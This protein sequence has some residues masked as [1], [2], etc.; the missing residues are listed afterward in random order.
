MC[1][2]TGLWNLN[3]E[4]VEPRVFD[5]FTD[6]LA[7]RGP[8]GRGVYIDAQLPLALGQRR[9]AIIDTSELG[10]QPMSY[11]DGRYWIV[12][13]GEIYNFLELRMELLA[14]GYQF[15]TDSDTE[16]ILAAYDRWGEDCLLRFNGM[17]AMA[18]WD[19]R[20][21]QLFVSRDRFGVK[22]M[23]YFY[24]GER[25]A[26]ASEM[27]AFLALDW[28]PVEF[29]EEMIATALT[30][31]HLIEGTER[32]LL[33][34][35]HRLPGGHCLT[36]RADG[37]LVKKRWWNTLDHLTEVPRR[38]DDQAER[39]KELF[40]DAC[41]IRMRSD[42]AIGTAL[43][44]GLDSSSV[45][46]AMRHIRHSSG[47]M[48]RLAVDWQRA[49]TAT[50]PGT[51]EDERKYAEEVIA[52]TGAQAV[53]SEIEPAMMLRHYND[54][55]FQFEEISDIHI[56][57]WQ[58][59]KAQRENNVIVSIDGHGG[60]ELLGGY[61]YHVQAALRDALKPFPRPWRHSDLK[62]T[63][64][65]LDLFPQEADYNI[66]TFSSLLTEKI[67]AFRWRMRGNGSTL[68]SSNSWLNYRP[69]PFS[70][71]SLDADQLRLRKRNLLFEKLYLS[72]HYADLP[73]NLRDFDRLSMAHGVEVRAPFLDWRLVTYS[74]SLPSASKM[75]YG[76]TK[77]ILR[78]AM[79]GVLT[80]SI[81]VRRSKGGF[82]NPAG[83]W[84]ANHAEPFIMDWL[85]SERFINSS[86]WHGRQIQQD[87][88][89]AFRTDNYY[90][91]HRGWLYLQAMHLMRLFRERATT[92]RTLV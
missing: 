86:I 81:R 65:S 30:H 22:P 72:F 20:I 21:K 37:S 34:R 51:P 56:G 4:F 6:S 35:L 5:M 43:S 83:A 28:F 36:V 44:G 64:L 60:D 9:L 29:D 8:D 82:V 57:P 66:P 17:W 61:Y 54:I 55:L 45:L 47:N 59:Y 52:H 50:Y 16:V 32:C 53:Y 39:F 12:Y 84:L 90:V 79:R 49:F 89:N 26:F 88:G 78:D 23:H 74:F 58:V 31:Y 19:R 77:R 41:R 7:H 33:K 92:S 46:S 24:D 10:R 91:I 40:L 87:V 63:L 67:E 1:G 3:G 18:I 14:M 68:N 85:S 76:F 11:A 62:Q 75:G 70:P 80:E 73:T 27:K 42:V 15:T 2:I 13:N 71:T 48:E 25:F 38:Y 69:V